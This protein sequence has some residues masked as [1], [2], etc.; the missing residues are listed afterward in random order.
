MS[1]REKTKFPLEKIL[2]EMAKNREDL[3]ARREMNKMINEGKAEASFT[4]D[5]E[6]RVTGITVKE[7]GTGKILFY[8]SY[9][10]KN[11]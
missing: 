1:D 10:T 11:P 6:G 5:P 8:E 4:R 2:E 9:E 7:S 3:A